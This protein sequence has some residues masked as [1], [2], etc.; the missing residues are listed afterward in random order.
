MQCLACDALA[1]LSP[2]VRKASISDLLAMAAHRN[3]ADPRGMVNR[4]V[5]AALF[6]PNPDLHRPGILQHSL[7]GIDRQLLYPAMTTLLQNDDALTRYGL[8]PYVNQLTDRDLAVLLPVIIQAV[9]QLAPSDEMFGDGIRVAG[10]D[11]LSRLHIREGMPLCVSVM[12]PDRW[13]EGR[14]IPQCLK[15]LL[16]YGVHAK[17]VLPQL[18]ETSRHLPASM[19]TQFQGAF[20]KAIADIEAAT[21]SP[22]LVSLKDFIARATTSGDSSNAPNH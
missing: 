21:D 12:E 11:L 13:G 14:R 6:D 10:L 15:F 5:A 8:V 20:D 4:S 7:V 18:R 2:E 17:Q 9:G 19:V 16:R 1:R 22:P 3:P